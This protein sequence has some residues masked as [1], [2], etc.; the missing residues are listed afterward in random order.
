MLQIPVSNSNLVLNLGR[1]QA[2]SS[3]IKL[4]FEPSSG[5]N[6]FEGV[7]KRSRAPMPKKEAS[8][9]GD[10]LNFGGRRGGRKRK[11]INICKVC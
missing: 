5:L 1:G 10:D 9:G 4:L 7:S 3:A 6:R 8:T 11:K 2:A